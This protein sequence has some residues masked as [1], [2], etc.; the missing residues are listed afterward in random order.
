MVAPLSLA[1]SIVRPAYRRL[2]LA[3]FRFGQA[4]TDVYVHPT[5]AVKGSR[6]ITLGSAVHIHARSAL[7]APDGCRIALADHCRID[8][9]VTLIADASRCGPPGSIVVGHHGYVGPNSVLH[10][11]GGLVIGCDVL[12][13]PHVIIMAHNHGFSDAS[14]PIRLQTET[15]RGITIGDDVWIGAGAAIMDGARIGRGS[16]IGANAVVTGEIPEMSVAVG[17]PARVIRRR[18]GDA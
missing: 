17:V 2:L 8:A 6:R 11:D 14:T 12:I 15:C 18:G 4:G 5:V 7:H 1:K 13:G 9:G 16:V 3:W 10:G